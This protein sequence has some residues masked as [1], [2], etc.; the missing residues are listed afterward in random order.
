MTS[1]IV[2]KNLLFIDKSFSYHITYLSCS[3]E[4]LEPSPFISLN[5][6]SSGFDTVSAFIL[7]YIYK[8]KIYKKPLT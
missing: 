8:N 7:A 3:L 4:E 5:N 6:A 1:I 2:N